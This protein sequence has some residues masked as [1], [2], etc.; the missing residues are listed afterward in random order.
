MAAFAYWSPALWHL[1][2]TG[3]G[4][5]RVFHHQWEAARVALLRY[6]E[7]PLWDP[8]H[9]GGVFLFGDPQAQ[10]Y[11]PLYIALL[12]FG[13]TV[14]LKLFVILHAAAGFAGA[15][16]L[17]RR[18]FRLERIP[19]SLSALV[20]AGSG[21]FAWHLSGGHAA[22]APFYLAPLIVLAFRA[23]LLSWRASALL[24]GLMLLTLLEGGVYP[25]PLFV[26]LLV[27]EACVALLSSVDGA[28]LGTRIWRVLRAGALSGGLTLL[29]G[30][31]RLLPILHTMEQYPR[32]TPGDDALSWRELLAMFV[33]AHHEYRFGH[34]FVWGEY[35]TYIGP[36]AL[37][38][39]VLGLLICFVPRGRDA[40]NRGRIL[41]GCALFLGFTLG[42]GGALYPWTLL[43]HLPVWDSLRV[44][45]R[46]VVLGSLYLAL[47]A[48]LALDRL[49]R[50]L[51][52]RP[53]WL[54]RVATPLGLL[55]LGLV[56]AQLYLGNAAQ[57]DRWRGAPLPEI[58]ETA[59]YRVVPASRYGE[60]QSFPARNLGNAGCYTGME[61]Y[62][63]AR[64][65]WVGPNL[66]RARHGR[67]RSTELTSSTLTAQVELSQP[68]EVSFDQT[69]APGWQTN[70]GEVAPG[71]RGLLSVRHIPEGSHELR[72]RYRP[73]EIVPASWLLGCGLLA[74]L[75]VGLWPRRKRR[76]PSTEGGESRAGASA[77]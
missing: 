62:H 60:W 27:F 6:G 19:A 34:T 11:S 58:D 24:A 31:F 52:R 4:D 5:W 17:A 40:A 48:G 20:W 56:A 54:R 57:I 72:L 50:G 39:A 37:A 8:W 68:G 42:A 12:P 21:F 14:G 47:A 38:L 9:C 55:T 73:M 59:S 10:I 29:A 16:L 77:A 23:S 35:G 26:L 65:L 69:W 7:F 13:T 32:P 43:H 49:L 30:G 36:L 45:S 1:Q 63:T 53:S 71:P 66:A 15:Y 3:F 61:G 25:F 2:E 64:G 67:V 44:P 76:A 51:A 22:F 74:L 46:F 28:R 18:E 75:V 41:A 70:I 33:D